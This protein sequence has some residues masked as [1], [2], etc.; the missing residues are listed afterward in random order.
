VLVHV[1]EMPVYLLRGSVDRALGGS[2]DFCHGPMSITAA[3]PGLSGAAAHL[4]DEQVSGDAVP[5]SPFFGIMQADAVGQFRHGL[6]CFVGK[7]RLSQQVDYLLP[8][9]L[10]E[11]NLLVEEERPRPTLTGYDSPSRW[12]RASRHDESHLID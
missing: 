8:A 10:H 2:L 7:P 6:V 1:G 12:R 11:D 3:R 5:N 9:V 4:A